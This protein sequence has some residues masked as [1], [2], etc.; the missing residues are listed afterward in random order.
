MGGSGT[1]AVAVG[2]TAAGAAAAAAVLGA[3]AA[4]AALAAISSLSETQTDRYLESR[5]LKH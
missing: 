5:Y 4:T 3:A 1:V 2:E